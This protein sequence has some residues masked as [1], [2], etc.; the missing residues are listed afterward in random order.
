MSKREVAAEVRRR[1]ARDAVSRYSE[2]NAAIEAQAREEAEKARIES[3]R[4]RLPAM[5][6]RGMLGTVAMRTAVNERGEE[7]A[8]A[9]R[10]AGDLDFMDVEEAVRAGRFGHRF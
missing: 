10:F 7:I 6:R 8:E 1:I 3:I 5:V 9:V 2:E 4:C